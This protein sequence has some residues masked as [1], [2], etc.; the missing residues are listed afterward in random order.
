MRV[1]GRHAVSR[2]VAHA[3][4]VEHVGSTD[5]GQSYPGGWEADVVLR[6]GGVAHVR[7]IRPQDADAVQRFHAGQSAESIYLRF[8]APVHELPARDLK[9]FTEVDHN[10]RVALVATIGDRIVGI[11][12]YE[13][14]EPAVA[15]VAFNIADS[16]QGR[17]IGSVL[18][19]HLAA[20]ARERAV[21]RFV[22]DV[23]PQNRRMLSVF[24]EAGYEITQR[25]DDG[26]ISLG[27]DIERTAL[28]EEVREA[29][30][31]S[32]EALSVRAVLHPRSVAV[33]GASREEASGGTLVLRYLLEA[34]FRGALHVVNPNASTVLGLTSYAH[35]TDVPGVVDMAVIAVPAAIVEEVVR[36]CAEAGARVLLVISDGFAETGARGVLRQ[37]SLVRR[38][39]AEGMRVIG[40]N[41]FGVINTDDDIRLNASL[42]PTMPAP[43][44]LALFSQSGALGIQVLAS[45]TNRGIGV[46][47]FVSAGN[48]ADV[49]GNDLMQYWLDDQRTTAVGLYLESVGNPRKFSRVAR[50]LARRK[51]VIVVKSGVT[52]YGVPP[53]HEVRQTHVPRGAFDAMLRQ[54][55]V[56]RVPNV[57]QMFDVAQLVLSQPLPAGPRVGIVGNS[58]SMNALAAEASVSWGLEVALGPLTVPPQSPAA[59]FMA[60]LG[61]VFADPS[62]DAVIASFVSPMAARDE[63]LVRAVADAA[64]TAGKTCVATF[65]GMRGVASGS[66]STGGVPTYPTPEDAVRALATVSRYATWLR[67]GP[68]E[69]IT[70]PDID[71][72]AAR[73]LIQRVLARGA[74]EGQ[75]AGARRVTMT[76]EQGARLL[77]A[78]GVQLWPSAAVTDVDQAIAAA[79]RFQ[80]PVALKAS[81][82][83]V[84]Q[85]A[86]LVARRLTIES[87]SELRQAFET[88]SDEL[89]TYG[90]GDATLLVQPMAAPGIACMLRTTEDPLFGPVVSFGIAGAASELLDDV[91][92]RIPPLT[93]QDVGDLV[94]SIRAAP[95]LYGHRGAEPLDVDALQDVIARVAQLADDLPEVADLEVTPVLVGEFGAAVLDVAVELSLAAR[96]DADRRRLL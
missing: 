60:A 88:L 50:R 19:E 9:R 5:P 8:F 6:D 55:G 36:E 91:A 70:L 22:A 13:R 94:T 48:R 51:P 90:V 33:V 47:T 41:S 57:H 28:S 95:L 18:L 11:A 44:G 40:P 15:D 96:S 37:R 92:H 12:R 29:R 66:S 39:R 85:R 16:D 4:R 93:D 69:R 2:G 80:Y 53:G 64:A 76:R 23:L 25:Y 75:P 35:V 63:A 62:V 86:D 10:D 82:P 61:T 32:A 52:S 59:D 43:G 45:A 67:R 68:G 31:H 87:E 24:E 58:D 3:D 17:G 42:A 21:R 65:L 89:A 34:Q 20:A 14:T 26:V 79:E 30:E 74:E 27:F 81:D 1:G 38:A 72:E 77:A 56:I 49:S 78:Y 83:T 46:S 7:P 71:V 84:R 73:A 54:A